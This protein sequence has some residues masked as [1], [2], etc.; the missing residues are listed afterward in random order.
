MINEIISIK[1]MSDI[2]AGSKTKISSKSQSLY[3]NILNHWF[4]T[5]SENVANLSQFSMFKSDI[6]YLSNKKGFDELERGGLVK[7]E[8]EKV[9]FI[10]VWSPLIPVHL[11][12]SE[13]FKMILAN[14][15]RDEMYNSHSLYD[16][17]R[18][19]YRGTTIK[20]VNQLLQMFFAEQSTLETKYNTESQVKKH[21]VYWCANNVNKTQSE[22]AKSSGK[23]LGKT[24]KNQ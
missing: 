13:K 18:M 19:K 23:I 3:Q 7:I 5:K 2:F 22:K 17:V 20:Q 15:V 16:L 9:V 11:L 14:E 24:T 21:F 4:S 1:T 10:D 12:Q 8:S 6:K